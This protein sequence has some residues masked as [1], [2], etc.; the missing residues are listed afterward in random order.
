MVLR[1]MISDTDLEKVVLKKPKNHALEPE[2]EDKH[3]TRKL[4]QPKR[5]KSLFRKN[6]KLMLISMAIAILG[7]SFNYF[8][9]VELTPSNVESLPAE[10]EVV[11]TSVVYS[12]HNASAVVSGKIVHEGDIMDGYKV[13]KI[14]KNNVEFEKDGKSYTK[15]V[16]NWRMPFTQKLINVR[17]SIKSAV[18]NWK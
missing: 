13:V 18:S 7:I 11:V 17:D 2:R 9:T 10:K 5:K 3:T 6:M 14:F 1:Y 12:D 4:H 16:K 15:Y 8:W